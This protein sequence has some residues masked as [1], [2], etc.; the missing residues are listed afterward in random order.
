MNIDTFT[1]YFIDKSHMD[2]GDVNAQECNEFMDEFIP[3][4][5]HH[6][7]EAGLHFT[8]FEI[9]QVSAKLWEKLREK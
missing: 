9:E 3:V 6:L 4:I 2:W 8:P 5:R 7:A 1:Q